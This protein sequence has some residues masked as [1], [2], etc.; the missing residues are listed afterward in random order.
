M[1]LL[2]WNY[3]KCQ[4]DIK[5]VCLSKN[6]LN[7]LFNYGI[8]AGYLGQVVLLVCTKMPGPWK[9]PGNNTPWRS[10]WDRSRC[11]QSQHGRTVQLEPKAGPRSSA[12]NSAVYLEIN[13]KWRWSR[14]WSDVFIRVH[15]INDCNCHPVRICSSCVKSLHPGSQFQT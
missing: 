9:V 11:Q 12:V 8:Y 4:H 1:N 6:R 15:T 14:S 2:S 10:D 7:L 5:K 13:R 3:I